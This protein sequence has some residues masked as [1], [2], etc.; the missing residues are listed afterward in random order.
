VGSNERESNS[1]HYYI[2]VVKSLYVDGIVQMVKVKANVNP[3]NAYADTDGRRRHSS[4]S[5]ALSVLQG[6]GWSAPHPGRFTP[7]K[8]QYPLCRRKD[9]PRGWSVR[10]WKISPPP[11]FDPRTVQSLVNRCTDRA[12]LAVIVINGHHKL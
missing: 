5:F 11:G 12:V 10:A 4:N 8:T 7:G 3:L 6:G 9:G 2:I 1:T